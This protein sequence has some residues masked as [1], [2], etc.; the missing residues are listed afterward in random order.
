MN[1][2]LLTAVVGALTVL[3]GLTGL[4]YPERVMGLLGFAAQNPAHAAAALGEIRAMYGGAIT[5]LGIAT[6]LAAVD[7]AAHRGRL[8]L[9]GAVWVGAAAGRL[10]GV[11]VDGNPGVLAWATVAFEITMGGLLLVASQASAEVGP[12]AAGGSTQAT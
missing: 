9:L 5:V 10:F 4:F 1:P 6:L 7:P 8:V 3:S 11:S 2:R 12:A